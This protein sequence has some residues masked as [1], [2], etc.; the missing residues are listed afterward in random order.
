[1]Y[2]IISSFQMKLIQSTQLMNRRG[3]TKA[4]FIHAYLEQNTISPAKST[5]SEFGLRDAALYL[6][7]HH[8]LCTVGMSSPMR[9]L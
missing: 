1:M 8:E 4:A 2:S 6:C 5:F 3:K 9:S 7:N